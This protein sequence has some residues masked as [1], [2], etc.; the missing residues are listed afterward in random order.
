MSPETSPNGITTPDEKASYEHYR[1][2]RGHVTELLELFQKHEV[3]RAI[4]YR[5]FGRTS[6]MGYIL[7]LDP[8][9]NSHLLIFEDGYMAVTQA[10]MEVKE[11]GDIYRERMGRNIN[12]Y[13][14]SEKRPANILYFLRLHPSGPG[15]RRVGDVLFTNESSQSAEKFKGVASDALKVV[16]QNLRGRREILIQTVDTVRQTIGSLATEGVGFI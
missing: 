4:V 2:M 15:A 5:D 6:L 16:R 11:C 12:D 14:T 1:N 7:P 9:D 13:L 10:D 8:E 3:G